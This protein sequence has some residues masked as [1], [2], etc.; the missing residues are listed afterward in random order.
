MTYG[1]CSG[2]GDQPPHSAEIYAK[3][4][5]W[6]CYRAQWRGNRPPEKRKMIICEDC[7]ERKPHRARNKCDACYM[8]WYRAQNPDQ[9]G[10]N[11]PT[12]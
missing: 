8:R 1:L 2:Y 11:V 12:T 9:G 5:C 6:K 4:R 7:D 3:G 10:I